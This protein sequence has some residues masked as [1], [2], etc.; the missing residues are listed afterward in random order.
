MKYPD[1]QDIRLG[2]KVKL[3]ADAEGW[4]FVRL[5]SLSAVAA[6]GHADGDPRQA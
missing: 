4:S 5:T 1:G 3:G 6:Q 2:D